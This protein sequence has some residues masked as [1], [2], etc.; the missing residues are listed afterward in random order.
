MFGTPSLKEYIGIPTLAQLLAFGIEYNFPDSW[1]AGVFF[2]AIT[3]NVVIIPALFLLNEFG[4]IEKDTTPEPR[5]IIDLQPTRAADTMPQIKAGGMVYSQQT[6]S[7]KIDC[8]AR[9][10][11]TLLEQKSSKLDVR[12]DETFWLK[13]FPGMD[14]SN[15]TKAGGVGR[16]D[17]VNM[18]E[19]GIKFGAYKTIGGQNKRAPA[20]WSKI[21][22]LSNGNP[23][24][25]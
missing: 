23:L 24:P 7:L 2:W 16:A 6:A 22:W 13:K 8:V 5:H 11:R 15:W 12:M 19:R 3:F 14:E 9:F 4:R 20:D 17:F 21:R 1:A 18:L 25:Q 10:N